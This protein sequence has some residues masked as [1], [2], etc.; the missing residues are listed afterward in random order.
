MNPLRSIDPDKIYHVTDRTVNEEFWMPPTKEVKE[1][2]GGIIARFQEI[3]YI[4]IFGLN[5]LSNHYHLLARSPYGNLSEF[6]QDINR[7]I[8]KRMNRLHGRRGALWARRFSSQPAPKAVDGLDALLYVVTNPVHHGLVSHPRFWPRLNT[9]WQHLG[10]KDREYRFTNYTALNLARARSKGKKVKLKNFQTTHTLKISPL[11][12]FADLSK[13]ERVEK[14]SGLIEERTKKLVD[15][16][17]ENGTALLGKKKILEQAAGSRPR[18]VKRSPRPSCF[19]KCA[20]TVRVYKKEAKALREEYTHASIKYRSGEWH[21]EFPKYTHRPPA[22][23]HPRYHELL[24][25]RVCGP[26]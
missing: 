20:E 5:I 2:I 21:T 18:T 3:H 19:S 7:E 25:E 15:A 24:R 1:A 4:D 14:L 10:A 22:H 12:M 23:R 6:E 9:Y 16:A 17:K 26:P 8:A 11:P 13:E